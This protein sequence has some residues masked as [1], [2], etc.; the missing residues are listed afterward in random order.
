M[1]DELSARIDEKDI[2][3]LV[4][5]LR[6]EAGITTTMLGQ[7]VGVSQAQISRLE[8]GKQGFRSPT[9][10]K[11]AEALGYDA[12]VVFMPKAQVTAAETG[13]ATGLRTE[14]GEI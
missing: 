7:R 3:L 6:T 5:R 9:L 2:G 4:N 11:I 8:N 1:T 13:G 12:K 14:P 10:K